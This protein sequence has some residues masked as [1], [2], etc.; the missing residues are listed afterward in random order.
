ME[1]IQKAEMALDIKKEEFRQKCI[2]GA[3]VEIESLEDRLDSERKKI[4]KY[5]AQ[6]VISCMYE[7]AGEPHFDF[8][9]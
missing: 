6:K 1:H 2:I 3:L 7:G 5:S 9:D 8:R 4:Q